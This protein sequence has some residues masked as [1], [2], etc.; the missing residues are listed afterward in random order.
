MLPAA[1]PW[2]PGARARAAGRRRVR[3]L[4]LPRRGGDLPRGDRAPRARAGPAAAA[5]ARPVPVRQRLAMRVATYASV[6]RPRRRVRAGGLPPGVRRRALAR[7]PGLGADRS[8]RVRDAPRGGAARRRDGLGRRA[9][10]IGHRAGAARSACARSRRSSLETACSP[11]SARSS[12]RRR[13]S[14]AHSTHG[15]PRDE[16]RR[17]LP[18]DRH[19]RRPRPRAARGRPSGSITSRS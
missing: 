16:G 4:P 6:D 15:Q 13:H 2:R 19:A 10:R 11:A 7:G 18:A 8:R 1:A 5:L 12:G 14:C 17:R 9:A 3:R